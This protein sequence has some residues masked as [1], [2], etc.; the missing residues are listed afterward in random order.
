LFNTDGPSPPYVALTEKSLCLV[1]QFHETLER[2]TKC[3]RSDVM[4]VKSKVKA[5]EGNGLD[6]HGDPK[7]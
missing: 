3:G 7:P 2:N 4:K 1:A 6:P 5:G